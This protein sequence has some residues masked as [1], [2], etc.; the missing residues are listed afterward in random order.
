MQQILWNQGIILGIDEDHGL[1]NRIEIE[2]RRAPLI[3]FLGGGEI[4]HP[5]R[6][7]LIQ[8]GQCSSSDDLALVEIV[9]S[10]HLIGQ[11]DMSMSQDNAL[12]VLSHD[13]EVETT[14][15]LPIKQ[16]LGAPKMEKHDLVRVSN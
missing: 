8:F 9:P 3:Q 6:I 10:L 1:L 14:E 5:P 4:V 7:G 11:Q 12:H 2:Q 16:P 15:V 13:V